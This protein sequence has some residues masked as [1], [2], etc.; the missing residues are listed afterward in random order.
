MAS[1]IDWFTTRIASNAWRFNAEKSGEAEWITQ[2]INS[3]RVIM[4]NY[5]RLVR[6]SDKG[7][8]F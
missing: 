6:L 2:V 1:L 4:A 5:R 8:C 3:S 7:Y